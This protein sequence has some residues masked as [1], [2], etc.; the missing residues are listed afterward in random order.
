MSPRRLIAAL[1]AGVLAA[2]GLSACRESRDR[3]N[4]G[5]VPAKTD[6][7]VET[8]PTT[9]GATTKTEQTVTQPPSGVTTP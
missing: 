6:A 8:N 7:T 4:P 5:D 3:S 9:L 1:L 2:G